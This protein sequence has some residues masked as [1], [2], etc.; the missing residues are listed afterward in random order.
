MDSL[1]SF[2]NR[3][4]FGVSADSAFEKSNKLIEKFKS[5]SERSHSLSDQYGQPTS[6]NTACFSQDDSGLI[7]VGDEDGNVHIYDTIQN[8]FL[9]AFNPHRS[10]IL[11]LVWVPTAPKIITC[12]ADRTIVVSDSVKVQVELSFLGHTNS[13]RCLDLSSDHP[14]TFASGGRDGR[15]LIWDIRYPRKDCGSYHPINSITPFKKESVENRHQIKVTSVKFLSDRM[16]ATSGDTS[17]LIKVWDT[18]RTY[19]NYKGAPLP[20]HTFCPEFAFS[21]NRGYTCL[22]TDKSGNS[23]Y[24][25]GL[26]GYI[27]RFST[28]FNGNTEIDNFYGHSANSFYIR[29]CLSSNDRWLLSGSLCGKAHMW[30]VTKPGPHMYTLDCGSSSSV[31]AVAWSPVLIDNIATCSDD[32]ATFWSMESHSEGVLDKYYRIERV[33]KVNC[34]KDL[35][36]RKKSKRLKTS[37]LDE[38][39]LKIRP[40]TLENIESIDSPAPEGNSSFD[41]GVG[42]RTEPTDDLNE[43]R[44][45]STMIESMQHLAVQADRPMNSDVPTRS[46]PASGAA[47]RQ[48][49]ISSFL[50]SGKGVKRKHS[51]EDMD[52]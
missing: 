31:L 32:G 27:R 51:I 29:T 5:T 7:A 52:I 46:S 48:S 10:A 28:S 21:V 12:S 13:V 45:T 19:T 33:E 20:W 35:D 40:D 14:T 39:L 1:F 25:S 44:T 16:L 15:V 34:L 4:A 36:I 41:R 42:V 50:F 11:D 3:R 6:P 2:T 9:I 23:L 38:Y 18:R 49:S 8:K 24:A 22:A 30:D 17:H 43:S 26:N 47:E 37:T